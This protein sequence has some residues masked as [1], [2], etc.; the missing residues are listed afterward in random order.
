M[1]LDNISKGRCEI[2]P[3]LE[4]V[5]SWGIFDKVFNGEI[6]YLIL[7]Y[8]THCSMS[9]ITV[10]SQDFMEIIIENYKS[11]TP[12]NFCCNKDIMYS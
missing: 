9:K 4:I 3:F 6:H 12:F 11:Q 1:L 2:F 8:V 7:K 5:C 10:H